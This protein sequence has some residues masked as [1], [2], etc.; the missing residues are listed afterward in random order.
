MDLGEKGSTPMNALRWICS[1]SL[2]TARVTLVASK[3]HATAST[4]SSSS[5]G[6]VRDGSGVGYGS[7]TA[8]GSGHG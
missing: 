1:S 3:L 8:F 5:R 6:A 7:A 2:G 4:V